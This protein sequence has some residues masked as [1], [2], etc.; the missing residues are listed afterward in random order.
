MNARTV[1]VDFAFAAI[2]LDYSQALS[3]GPRA[4][5]VRLAGDE[6]ELQQ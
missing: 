6:K 2:Y 4:V 3:C 1:L 5:R